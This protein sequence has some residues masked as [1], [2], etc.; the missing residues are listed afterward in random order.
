LIDVSHD[1]ITAFILLLNCK[2]SNPSGSSKFFE[3]ERT[4]R[5]FTTLKG[6]FEK[7]GCFLVSDLNQLSVVVLVVGHLR[8]LALIALG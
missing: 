3:I 8:T 4:P 5:T 7:I 2:S 6:F 1:V